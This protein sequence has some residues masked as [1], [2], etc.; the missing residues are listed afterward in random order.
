M[1][2]KIEYAKKNGLYFPLTSLPTRAQIDS[3]IATI[4]KDLPDNAIVDLITT[5]FA[6]IRLLKHFWLD[7]FNYLGTRIKIKSEINWEFST[8][9]GREEQFK[10]LIILNNTPV[11]FIEVVE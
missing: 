7:D 1:E 9:S 8:H 11:A 4:I 3:I 10:A 2:E 6:K 5:P